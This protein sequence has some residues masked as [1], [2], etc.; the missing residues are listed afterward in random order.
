MVLWGREGSNPSPGA[1]CLCSTP[2]LYDLRTW[3]P[4]RQRGERQSIFWRGF[5]VRVLV[6]KRLQGGRGNVK[7]K[8]SVTSSVAL[9]FFLLQRGCLSVQDLIRF[10]HVRGAVRRFYFALEDD[11]SCGQTYF[12]SE[13]KLYSCSEV[14]RVPFKNIRQEAA[15]GRHSR[16]ARK[17][18]GVSS[19]SDGDCGGRLGFYV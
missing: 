16:A 1:I 3:T 13:G 7:A 8:S 18:V 5:H 17:G 6:G 10:V 12:T 2:C 11:L 19:S 4:K 14:C 9:I 15:Y